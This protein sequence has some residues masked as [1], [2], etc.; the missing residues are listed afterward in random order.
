MNPVTCTPCGSMALMTCQQVPSLPALSM[1]CKYDQQRM[2]AVGVEFALQFG[3]PLQIALQLL[4]RFRVIGEI[5]MEPR[6]DRSKIDIRS[7]IELG[8]F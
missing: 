1:P 5:A 6:I 7:R 4:R 8:A 3:D 2:R